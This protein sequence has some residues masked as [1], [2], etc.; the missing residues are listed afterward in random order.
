MKCLSFLILSVLFMVL[1]PVMCA[2]ELVISGYVI[3][4]N[5]GSG[6]PYC[7]IFNETSEKQGTTSDENGFFQLRIPE[8]HLEDVIHFSSLG[9]LVKTV[10]VKDLK[11]VDLKISL[12]PAPVELDDFVVRDF[13]KGEIV[14]YGDPEEPIRGEGTNHKQALRFLTLGKG[15]GVFVEPKRRDRG[16]FNAIEIFITPLGKPLTPMAIRIMEPKVRMKNGMRE[17]LSNFRD[18]LKEPLIIRP[19]KTGWN[20]IDLK[21]LDISIPREKFLVI[22]YPLDIGEEGQWTEKGVVKYGPVIGI[23]DNHK[24]KSIY[25]ARQLGGTHFAILK[26]FG[27][28]KFRIPAVVIH[29]YKDK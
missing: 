13:D 11:S 6:I 17:P 29:W 1:K 23:Y 18:V 10:L 5:D 9:Y 22:F 8:G 2:T 3:S 20:E 4:E 28:N 24:V 14:M 16:Y 25:A 27:V 7:M 12:V 26:P 15:Y 19:S 21:S